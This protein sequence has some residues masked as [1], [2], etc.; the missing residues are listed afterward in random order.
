MPNL[1]FTGGSATAGDATA[2]N[3]VFAPAF[4]AFAVGGRANSQAGATSSASGGTA[5]TTGTRWQ[6]WLGIA[7]AVVSIAT[8]L[9]VILRRK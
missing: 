6:L 9:F 1:S 8:G 3:S 7:A 5:Q 2:G 4:G